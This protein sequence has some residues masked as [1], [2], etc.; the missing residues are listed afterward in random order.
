MR[1]FTTRG[2]DSMVRLPVAL[3][4]SLSGKVQAGASLATLCTSI[5]LSGEYRSACGS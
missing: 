2:T 5:C 1:L 3:S 4:S